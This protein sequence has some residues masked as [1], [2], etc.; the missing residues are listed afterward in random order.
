MANAE[1]QSSN[2]LACHAPNRAGARFCG[3]CGKQ[4]QQRTNTCRECGKENTQNARFCSSCGTQIPQDFKVC[5]SCGSQNNRG[6]GFCSNCA[7][8]FE[9]PADP[10]AVDKTEQPAGTADAEEKPAA[11][12]SGT[13]HFGLGVPSA[14]EELRVRST[15]IFGAARIWLHATTSKVA[16]ILRGGIGTAKQFGKK[17]PY[18][19]I[20]GAV[21]ASTVLIAAVVLTIRNADMATSG[22]TNIQD[23]NKIEVPSG[24]QYATRLAHIRNAPTSIGTIIVGDVLGGQ[25]VS[26]AWVL[27]RD[28]VTR[29][30]RIKRDDGTYGFIW[31]NNLSP[32]PPAQSGTISPDQPS[33]QAASTFSSNA[34]P[35]QSTSPRFSEFESYPAPPYGGILTRPDFRNAPKSYSRFRT[36]ISQGASQGANF[37][38]HY[39]VITIGCGT[40]CSSTTVVDVQSG[41]IFDFP[42][43]G[44]EYYNLALSYRPDSRLMIAHWQENEATNPTCIEGEFVL[45]RTSFRP[46][47]RQQQPGPCPT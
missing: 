40:D 26:G 25:A 28:G 35:E 37:A 12:S 4:F 46:T 21:A 17:N 23:Q 6:A 11:I 3:N 10:P 19:A 14:D 20:G 15:D 7:A 16:V 47:H 2:C 8:K 44:E 39:A 43:G 13:Y 34:T 41:K 1:T 24:T 30:L 5:A 38:G 29:W 42:L 27:G 33:S 45:V 18:I 36:V 22:T 32:I 9:P 31:G